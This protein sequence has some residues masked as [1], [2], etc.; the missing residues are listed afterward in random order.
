M[1]VFGWSLPPGCTQ[2]DIDDAFGAD[3]CEYEFHCS[4]P[5]CG[6]YSHESEDFLKCEA[7][8][9]L[10]CREH[11]VQPV[12]RN[13]SYCLE[14]GKCE[15]GERA[16]F[17]C[18]ECGKLWCHDHVLY[19]GAEDEDDE[20]GYYCGW[21]CQMA[22]ERGE[23]RREQ[24]ARYGMPLG[25]LQEAH[26]DAHSERMYQEIFGEKPEV[27]RKGVAGVG[28]IDVGALLGLKG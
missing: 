27:L 16:Y 7:C 3:E 24:I 26:I 2:R 6:E 28:A 13:E 8:A 22:F 9:A 10:I 25:D 17:A 4:A 14:H 18:D 12:D 5:D 19:V 20:A 15:C 21:R 23:L 11:A 1:S